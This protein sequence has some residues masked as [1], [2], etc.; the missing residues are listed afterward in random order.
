MFSLV[1][2]IDKRNSKRLYSMIGLTVS[3]LSKN[4]HYDCVSYLSSN[5]RRDSRTYFPAVRLSA[6]VVGPSTLNG[7]PMPVATVDQG[8]S[9]LPEVLTSWK[10]VLP[11]GLEVER[12]P[13]F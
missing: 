10:I 9:G 12:A 11:C 7:E 2:K 1:V 4:A 13:S 3:K 8:P 5:A 6:K